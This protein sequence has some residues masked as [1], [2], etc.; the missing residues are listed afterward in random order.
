MNAAAPQSKHA[1]VPTD[2][3]TAAAASM[4]KKAKNQIREFS[5]M[6]Y[7]RFRCR[8]V[9]K[10]MDFYKSCGMNV[11]FEGYQ[12]CI[13]PPTMQTAQAA[14]NPAFNFDSIA[15]KGAL[16][17]ESTPEIQKSKLHVAANG[18]IFAM[19]YG[20]SSYGTSFHNRVMLLFEEDLKYS[21]EMQYNKIE[22]QNAGGKPQDPKPAEHGHEYE[23]MVIYVHFLQRLVK[24]MSSKNYEVEMDVTNFDGVK[25]AIMRDPNNIQIRFIEMPDSYLNDSS[26]KQWFARLGYYSIATANADATAQLYE[27]LFHQRAA[28]KPKDKKDKDQMLA[29]ELPEVNIRK[30]GANQTVKNALAKGAGF[31]IVDMDDLII[32]LMNTVFYWLGNDMRTQACCLCVT[33]VGNA[34]TGQAITHH[35][36]S[37]SPLI[38]IGF[39]VPSIEAMINRFKQEKQ[40]FEW[41]PVRLKIARA[42][43]CARFSDKMNEGIYLELFCQKIETSVLPNKGAGGRSL[44]V[45]QKPIEAAPKEE[46]E[47]IINLNHIGGHSR[48]LS[49][50]AIIC[51]RGYGQHLLKDA[52]EKPPAP[53]EE[54]PIK[55]GRRLDRKIINMPI[56]E[57]DSTPMGSQDLLQFGRKPRVK[58]KPPKVK[59]RDD[60][61]REAFVTREKSK[62]V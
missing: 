20:G 27:S 32:G 26:K 53:P 17:K 60:L 1:K 44:S 52:V 37:I 18:R 57:N 39:E 7:F 46:F 15:K 48:N 31:R 36:P 40:E 2:K 51:P 59:E 47:F 43:M 56:A 12:E 14:K 19:S 5:K 11:D 13:K 55:G 3:A 62:S 58:P 8:D 4:I 25:L 21:Q 41:D 42:G 29:P 9:N 6:R 61:L 16:E 45:V 54:A 24:R 28:N 50:G 34:D 35:N 30:I 23:Y 49:E 22:Q 33:E 38:G 10:T